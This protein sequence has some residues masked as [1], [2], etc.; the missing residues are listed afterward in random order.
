MLR[1]ISRC[2]GPAHVW[3]KGDDPNS[4]DTVGV[5]SLLIDLDSEWVGL[6]WSFL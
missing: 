5:T 2:D 6:F 1:E 4:Y 3:L